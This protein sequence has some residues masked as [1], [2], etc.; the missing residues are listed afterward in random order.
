M[1]GSTTLSVGLHVGQLLQPIPG[2]IGRY[3]GELAR[4]LAGEGVRVVPF[5]A[6]RPPAG[7]ADG[8]VDL[9]WP[10]GALR[11]ELWHRLRRPRLD[12]AADLVHAPSLAVPPPGDAPLAV[13]VH[14]LAFLRLPQYFTIRGL[15]FHEQGLRLAR[16]QAAAIVVPSEFVAGELVAEGFD[17]ARVHVAHHGIEPVGTRDPAE[18]DAVLARLG[19]RRPF[20]LF[21]GTLEPRKGLETLIA[22][23]RVL[24]RGH[25][26]VQLALVGPRGWGKLP[27]LDRPGVVRLGEI[28]DDDLDALYRAA[29][30]LAYPTQY[31]GFGLP[32]LEAMVR[33]CP[34]V[35]SSATS[36]P[37]V[38]GDAGLLVDP[39]DPDA[40]ATALASVLDDPAVAERLG[41]AGRT[42]AAQFTW[43]ASIQSHLTAYRAALATLP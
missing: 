38:V 6:G 14:D 29:S 12:V 37:E 16:E 1:T 30:A 43:P 19:L 24:R 7:F 13:T 20:N 4:G 21:V 27:R 26:G 25:A 42:R 10:R 15:R 33:G 3:V 41:A 2:G 32:A 18:V 22:G 34:V 9:G 5:A 39:S 36:L 11:Y 28:T 40:L 8:Y 31:E 35:T 23:H 17:A